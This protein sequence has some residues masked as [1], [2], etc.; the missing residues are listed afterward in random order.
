[1]SIKDDGG[2]K[3][4]HWEM[5]PYPGMTLRDWFAGKAMSECLSE[6][7]RGVRSMEHG[8][9]EGWREGVAADAYKLADAMMAERDKRR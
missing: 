7:F 4:P 3:F 2:L 8:V 5:R 9:P 1:M 6:F